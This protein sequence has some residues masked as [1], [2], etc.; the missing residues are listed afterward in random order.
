MPTKRVL[1]QSSAL[2]VVAIAALVLATTGFGWTRLA[3]V[4]G[5]PSGKAVKGGGSIA[6]IDHDVYLLVGNNT[7]DFM[8]YTDSTNSWAV[9]SDMPQGPKKKRAKKGACLA[10]DNEEWIYALKGGSKNEFFRF[11]PETGWDSTLPEPT[12]VKGVKGGFACV[13]EIGEAQYLYAGAGSKAPEWLRFNIGTL[14]WEA[15]VPAT[16]P[17]EKVKIGS[18]LAFDGTS[19]LYF[20]AGGNK[21]NDFYALDLTALEPAWVAKADLPWA[22][23]TGKKKKVKEGG[24]LVWF[25]GKAYAVKGGSTREFWVYDPATD[26]W[27]WLSDL[28]STKGIKCGTALAAADE[29]I[30]CVPGKNTNEFFYEAIGT[31][32]AVQPRARGGVMAGVFARPGQAVSLPAGQLTVHDASGR[33]VFSGQS[34]GRLAL[35]LA[36][37]LYLART[38]STTHKLIVR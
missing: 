34:D 36:P 1:Q 7:R 8:R 31:G 35:N 30:Y 20:L 38:G 18:A 3:D 15:A 10:D 2:T 28:P 4:S 9:L 25:E 14:A 23:P 13:V 32:E 24:S 19:T 17:G 27:T 29:G 11:S 12:F 21:E 6:A 26:A 16:L 37:G 33:T 5:Q 22:G